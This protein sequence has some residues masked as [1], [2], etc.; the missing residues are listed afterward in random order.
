M[1]DEKEQVREELKRKYQE[2][3]YRL[4]IAVENF[5]FLEAEMMREEM[6]EIKKRLSKLDELY[7]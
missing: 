6:K 5:E 7:S 4:K 3:K 2:C 1:P